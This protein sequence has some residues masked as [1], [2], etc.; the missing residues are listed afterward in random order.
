LRGPVYVWSRSACV[1]RAISDLSSAGLSFPRSCEIFR[2]LTLSSGLT[3]D[4]PK[5][6]SLSNLTPRHVNFSIQGFFIILLDFNIFFYLI[7]PSP[8][9]LTILPLP[10]S[11]SPPLTCG[12]HVLDLLQPL[13]NAPHWASP[14]GRDYV[15][16]Q[17]AR[18]ARPG[19]PR[20]LLGPA[21]PPAGDG[22][23]DLGGDRSRWG[24]P[25]PVVLARCSCGSPRHGAAGRMC[26]GRSH[27]PWSRAPPGLQLVGG[28]ELHSAAPRSSGG[29]IRLSRSH[30]RLVDL[31]SRRRPGA[32]PAGQAQEMSAANGTARR[33]SGASPRLKMTPTLSPTQSL[34]EGRNEWDEARAKLSFHLCWRRNV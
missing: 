2:N 28:G 23:A 27:G 17:A 34:V 14:S 33:R 13:N 26:P 29:E 1:L 25:T 15:L 3:R 10:F 12:S 18:F 31:C 6:A 21:T 4:D 9:E 5:F 11:H 7:L 24:R 22:R 20:C 19:R 30:G 32:A 16:S 8:T